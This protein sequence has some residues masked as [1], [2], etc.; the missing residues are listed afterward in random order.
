VLEEQEGAWARNQDG[1]T[2]QSNV[3]QSCHA[4]R[5]CEHTPSLL[6]A[7][8]ADDTEYEYI[9][10]LG[11]VRRE[12]RERMTLNIDRAGD[13]FCLRIS[14]HTDP[15]SEMFIWYILEIVSR[16]STQIIVLILTLLER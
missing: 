6:K 3:S 1:R 11:S 16:Q 8:V 14:M 12:E 4:V 13:Q 9:L 15:R 7:L 2:A 5:G 10:G